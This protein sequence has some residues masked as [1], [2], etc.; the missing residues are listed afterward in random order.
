K[1]HLPEELFALIKKAKDIEIGG[2]GTSFKPTPISDLK[3][4]LDKNN[5]NTC[6]SEKPSTSSLKP[7]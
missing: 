1:K 3:A 6:Q 7:K 2:G 5:E 4:K